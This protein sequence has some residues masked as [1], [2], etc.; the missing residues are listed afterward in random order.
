MK[1]RKRPCALTAFSIRLGCVIFLFWLLGLAAITLAISQYIFQGLSEKGIDYAE[2]AAMV[3]GLDRLFSAEEEAADGRSATVSVSGDSQTPPYTR[4]ELDAMGLL[5]WDVY[6]DETAS[7]VMPADAVTIYAFSPEI[8]VYDAGGPVRYQGS[9]RHEN[10]LALLKTMGFYQ[11]VGRNRFYSG[12]SQFS[13]WNMIVFSSWQG[14]D[15]AN[16]DS[17]GSGDSPSAEYT[18]LTAMQASPL[19]IA[20][21]FLRNVYLFFTAFALVAFWLLRRSLKKNLTAPLQAVVEGMDAGWGYLPQLRD[22]PPR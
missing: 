12:A 13:L 14:D 18:L 1:E 6:F 15:L 20:A 8:F 9:E 11:N 19:R 7:A 22:R 5:A 16:E 2:Y 4:A 21:R 17:F 10:L 3:G